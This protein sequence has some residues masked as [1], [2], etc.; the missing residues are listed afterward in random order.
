LSWKALVAQVKHVPA[1]QRI[2]Y[3]LTHRFLKPG[4]VAIIP[5]GYADGFD[6]IAQSGRGEVLI[7][8]KRCSIAGR[9]CMNMFMVDVS[10]VSG[11]KAGDEVVLIGKQGR[12]SITAEHHAKLM[13]SNVYEVVARLN[14]LIQRVVH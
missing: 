11:V 5:I 3:D 10:H 1:K 4:K 6:R 2:G 9:V 8:G 7:R 14:S 12:Q 13:G